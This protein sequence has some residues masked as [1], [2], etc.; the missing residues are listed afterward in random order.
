MSPLQAVGWWDRGND[1]RGKVSALFHFFFNELFQI[2][3]EKRVKPCRFCV[4]QMSH[5]LRNS[6]RHESEC[7]FQTCTFNI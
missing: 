1:D 2:A 4:H 7:C 6:Y 3:F 5:N